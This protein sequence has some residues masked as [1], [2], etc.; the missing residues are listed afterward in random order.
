MNSSNEAQHHATT[1][2]A[3]FLRINIWSLKSKLL[4]FGIML[5]LIGHKSLAAQQNDGKTMTE[6]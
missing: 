5:T 6:S 3:N 2:M 1:I 4:I